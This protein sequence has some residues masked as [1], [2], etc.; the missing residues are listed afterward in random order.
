MEEA[1]RDDGIVQL[2]FLLQ[3]APQAREQ[4]QCRSCQQLFT[5]R[6]QLFHHLKASGH[7]EDGPEE[8]NL[9]MTSFGLGNDVFCRYYKEQGIAPEDVWLKAYEVMKTPQPLVLRATGHTLAAFCEERLSQMTDLSPLPLFSH[10]WM[11]TKM[12]EQVKHFLAAGQEV[13]IWHRQEWASMLPVLALDVHSDD[14]V[15]DLCAAPGSK[16]LQLLESLMDSTQ[17][18]LVANDVSR[19]RALVVAQR[20]RRRN[21]EGLLVTNCDGRDFPAF[22]T[23]NHR[24]MKFQKVL[25]DAPCF[26]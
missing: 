10:T 12:D 20:S 24:K 23:W 8:E 16:T 11:L 17:S 2:D 22:K 19:P 1:E 15:L 14:R 6:N 18:L 26:T 13:G 25:V 4:R 7:G 5:S 9:P 21:R 3:V